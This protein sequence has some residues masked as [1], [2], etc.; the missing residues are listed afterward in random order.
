MDN[1]AAAAGHTIEVSTRCLICCIAT[2]ACGSPGEL[3]P[4][5]VRQGETVRITATASAANA[6]MSGHT[7]R[8]FPE[9]SGTFGLMPVPVDEKP[10][11]YNVEILD[12]N[13]G[14]IDSAT[15][16]VRDAQ[17]PSQ[18]IVLSEALAELKPAPGEAEMVAAFRNLDS[19][20]RFW[21]EPLSAPVPGCMTSR[22]GVKRLRNGKP[23]GDHHAGL[24]MRAHAGDP[25]RATA[26]GTVII[27]RPLTLQ[28]GT[29]AIDHG[30][31]LE[32]M[33]MHMPKIQ[34]TEAAQVK[35]G[36]E[37]GY[38]GTTGRS[39]AP[40]L[41]W[42]IYVHGMAVSR[43]QWVTVGSCAAPGKTAPAKR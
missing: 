38:P 26:A 31:G 35:Q 33:Y 21:K 18:N 14:V 30:Q 7:I 41:H 6:R 13:G 9:G 2:V 16:T 43:L 34:A 32:S 25:I 37:I 28:G 29:V 15:A 24:D 3:P 1:Y 20:V 4:A 23:T 5:A 12:A 10:G 22:F 39:T 11:P 19:S 8:L 42:G 17:Y 36:E 27:A 40:H